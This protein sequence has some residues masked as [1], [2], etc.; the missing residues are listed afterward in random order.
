MQQ[1]IFQKVAVK[2]ELSDQE[3]QTL[4]NLVNNKADVSQCRLQLVII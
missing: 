2:K 1:V 4:V 3:L